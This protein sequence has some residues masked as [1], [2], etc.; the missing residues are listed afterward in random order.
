MLLILFIFLERQYIRIVFQ[1]FAL[2]FYE[3]VTDAY[4]NTQKYY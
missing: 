3:K 1:N 4:V 2:K